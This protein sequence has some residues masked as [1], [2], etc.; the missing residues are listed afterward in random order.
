MSSSEW[1]NRWRDVFSLDLRTLALFRFFLGIVL[2]TD[3]LNRFADLRAFYTDWGLMPRDWAQAFNGPLRLSLHFVNGDAWFAALLLA[4]ECLAGLA[5]A[6]GYRTRAAGMLTFVLQGSLLNRNPMILLGGDT[7]LACLLFWG[8][9]LPLN[10]RWS[11]DAVL[12]DEPPPQDN[13]HFS[14]AGIG[15]LVQVLSVYFF[16]A[17]LKDGNEWWPDG[18]AVY[19]TMTLER[20]SSPLGRWLLGA[21]ALMTGL[22]YFVYFL[23][24]LGPAIAL[25]PVLQRPLRFLVMISLMGMHLAFIVFMEIGHFPYVSL[26]SLTVLLGGWWWDWAEN[27][28]DHGRHLK[29]YYDRDCGF[30]LK[31]CLL[32]RHLL[33]VPRTEIMPA[34]N[35]E[36]ANALM[37]AQYSWVVIDAADVAHTKWNALVAII[38]DSLL[39]G[40]TWRLVSLNIWE[41]PGNTAYD[42]VGRH[43]AL[44]GR[45]TAAL[46]PS[47]QIRF[48]SS[49][50]AQRVAL[51]FVA[52][53]LVWNLVTVGWL[54]L[55]VAWAL[56]PVVRPLRLDQTWN[57]FAPTPWRDDGWYIVPGTLEDGSEID[58]LTGTAITYQK[59]PNIAATEPNIRWRTYH[60]L[61]W[62]RHYAENRKYYARWLCRDWNIRA[63]PGKHVLSLKLIYMLEQAVPPGQA[64]SIEQRVLWRH[65]CVTKDDAEDEEQPRPKD[66]KSRPV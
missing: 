44:F 20:Y 51:V 62:S 54:P 34:Q 2:A 32:L 13:R 17:L 57:M 16:S 38:R 39:F 8:L 14:A 49:A 42:W 61:I 24:L 56:E 22:T 40:W 4:V 5:L 29:I 47:R 11:V 25:S 45:L 33:I 59:P 35:S 30:C 46:L 9:F 18:T 21:P 66:G 27:R 52:L 28:V 41:K 19:Y 10:A 53:L 55:R 15:L 3:M 7:L 36:R 58:L 6:F 37:Q 63:D 60:T 43:R 31:A 12:A 48:E 26:C 50:S 65:E 23:E 64:S 1:R